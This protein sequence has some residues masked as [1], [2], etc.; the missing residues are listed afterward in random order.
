MKSAVLSLVPTLG[1]GG[2]VQPVHLG[3]TD[4]PLRFDEVELCAWRVRAGL[5][6]DCPG[7]PRQ[8]NGVEFALPPKWRPRRIRQGW[9]CSRNSRPDTKTGGTFARWRAWGAKTPWKCTSSHRTLQ[10][11]APRA[12]PRHRPQHRLQQL[13]RLHPPPPRG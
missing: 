1:L 4:V 6:N 10:Q 7:G 9:V 12:E 3:P 13:L 11:A 2:C 8:R 5:V